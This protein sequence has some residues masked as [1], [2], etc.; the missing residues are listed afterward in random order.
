MSPTMTAS[1]FVEHTHLPDWSALDHRIEAR[2]R[3]RTFGVGG[4]FVAAIA[5]IADAQDHHPDIE[6][7]YP[8]IVHITLTTHASGGI[9]DQ[10]VTLAQSISVLAASLNVVTAPNPT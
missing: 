1:E 10:D 9:T 5:H 2:F 3:G 6:L 7:A 8:G 4:V